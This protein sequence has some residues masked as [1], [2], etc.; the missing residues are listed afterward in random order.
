MKARIN[1]LTSS[2]RESPWGY[3]I[4]KSKTVP[5]E[6]EIEEQR[7]FFS[8]APL[9]LILISLNYSF[10]PRYLVRLRVA[11]NNKATMQMTINEPGPVPNEL[12]VDNLG[13]QIVSKRFHRKQSDPVIK[14]YFK[15]KTR[16]RDYPL[17]VTKSYDLSEPPITVFCS[18]RKGYIVFS[19]WTGQEGPFRHDD[20][21]RYEDLEPDKVVH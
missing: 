2:T 13:A 14:H 6:Q 12:D 8:S 17:I 21:V 16:E 19:L 3:S 20:F 11:E 10:S 4:M 1:C 18:R 9:E 7:N 15:K 5:T